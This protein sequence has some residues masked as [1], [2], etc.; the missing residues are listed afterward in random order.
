MNKKVCVIIGEGKSEKVFLSSLLV[1]KLD[2]EESETKGCIVFNS[3][4]DPNLFWIFPFPSCGINHKGGYSKLQQVETY[5]A[6]KIAIINKSFLLGNHPKL[7]YRIITD[8]DNDSVKMVDDKCKKINE[9]IEKS[10]VPREDCKINLANI[11]IESWFIAGLDVNSELINS[12]K[13][14]QAEALVNSVDIESIID[15]KEK[16]DDVLNDVISGN[17]QSIGNGFGEHID[18]E[19]ALIKSKSFKNFYEGLKKDNLI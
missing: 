12:H 13:K 2:F 1:N 7:Y 15:P 14:K 18:I 19:Q 11:E 10:G 8:T 5:I 16:L 6:C 4:K 17:R 9:A 3:K